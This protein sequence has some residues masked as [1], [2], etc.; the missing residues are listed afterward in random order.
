MPVRWNCDNLLW[1]EFAFQFI[2]SHE[3]TVFYFP[4]GRLVQD[5]SA[6][7]LAINFFPVFTINFSCTSNNKTSGGL[8]KDFKPRQWRPNRTESSTWHTTVQDGIT[9]GKCVIAAGQWL[10][11]YL[12]APK[13]H[14]VVCWSSFSLFFIRTWA[15][16]GRVYSL[17]Q[18]NKNTNYKTWLLYIRQ[19]IMKFI[20][21]IFSKDFCNVVDFFEVSLNE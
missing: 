10:L 12:V 5:F 21:G 19:E 18:S 20:N 15:D 14:F 17:C 1:W 13:S 2:T 11:F 4:H 3:Q 7:S 8:L 9:A 16:P 6:F